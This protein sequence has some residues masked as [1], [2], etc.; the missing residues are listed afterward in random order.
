MISDMQDYHD[1]RTISTRSN[2]AFHLIPVTPKQVK[3]ISYI[4]FYSN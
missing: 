2:C 4:K 3:A 1:T